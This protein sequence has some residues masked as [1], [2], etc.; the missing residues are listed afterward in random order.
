M[1]PEPPAEAPKHAEAG[2]VGTGVNLE[3]EFVVIVIS[4]M[5][6]CASEKHEEK[7]SEQMTRSIAN[8]ARVHCTH[9][10]VT[11]GSASVNHSGGSRSN[12]VRSC[13]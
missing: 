2:A 9:I 4:L 7:R 5:C 10:D 1:Q 11:F 8:A 12:A 3:E 6:F 13:C